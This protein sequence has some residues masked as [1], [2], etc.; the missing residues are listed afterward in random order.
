MITYLILC[1]FAT[2]FL[3]LGSS[4]ASSWG[5]GIG[6]QYLFNL[7]QVNITYTIPP[8][9]YS[10]TSITF[11][12][13][14]GGLLEQG[15]S[16]VANITTVAEENVTYQL[17]AGA[18]T[19]SWVIFNNSFQD[20][21]F[22]LMTLPLKFAKQEATLEEIQRGYTGVDYFVV[23]KLSSTWETFDSYDNPVFVA[24]I[25][26]LFSSGSDLEIQALSEINATTDE[27]LFDWYVNG[28][29]LANDSTTLFNIYY[30]LKLAY[31][32]SVGVIL[33]M[34]MA[35]SIDGIS[36]GQNYSI[37]LS[38]LVERDGYK[39]PAFRLPNGD[40]INLDDLLASLFPG[41]YWWLL[42]SSLMVLII[43]RISARKKKTT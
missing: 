1:I 19:E 40:S 28:T 14:G 36:D 15:E 27:C 18:L 21:L 11:G 7:N 5:V 38:S 20:D 31:E 25:K 33:G 8:A 30:N 9:N 17:S 12:G 22:G 4:Q 32:L 10:A 2:S 35:L 3:P 39:L 13:P 37:A 6:E 43:F 23:P 29:Y 24:T 34:R 42:P 41:F 26:S 16:F